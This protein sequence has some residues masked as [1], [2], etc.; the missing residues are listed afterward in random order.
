MIETQ[1]DKQAQAI[2]QGHEWNALVLL[3]QAAA[4]MHQNAL[5]DQRTHTA[6]F[7]EAQAKKLD[8]IF[9]ECFYYKHH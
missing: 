1:P 8:K 3:K 2:A 5:E 9:E 7:L 6:T 4:L